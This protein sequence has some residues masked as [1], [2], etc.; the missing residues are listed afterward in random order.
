MTLQVN[1]PAA[2]GFQPAAVHHH[3]SSLKPKTVH[4][5]YLPVCT[6]QYNSHMATAVSAGL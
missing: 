4:W 1:L 5:C 2:A 6:T 3:A